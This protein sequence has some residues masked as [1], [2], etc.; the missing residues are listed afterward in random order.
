MK[1][2]IAGAGEV[3]SHLAKMLSNEN[4]DIILI[5]TNEEHLKAVGANLDVLTYVGSATSISILK[6]AAIKNAGLFIAATESEE[7]NITAAILGKKL[8]ALKS[9]ARIDNPEFLYPGNRE[10]FTSFG[11]DY[12]I[13]PEKIAAKEIV[14]LL[15]KTGTTEVVDFDGGKLSLFVIKLE[16]NAPVLDKTM[17]EAS[18]GEAEMEFR[19]VAITRDNETLIPRGEDKFEANDLIYVI[20]NQYGIERLMEYSGKEQYDIR[21]IMILGGSRVGKMTAKDLGSHHNVKLIEIDRRKSYQ[22]SN[23]LDN[24]LV[25]NGD[26]RNIDLLME[27]GLDKM[28]AFIAVTGNSE[29]NMLSCLLARRMGVKKTIAEIENID[30]IRLAENMGIDTII[31]KKFITASRIFRF[32]MSEEVNS[33][34]CLTGTDAEVMEFIAKPDS[35]VVQGKIKDIDF[36]KDSIIG[37][38]IRGK[39]SF[40]A[41]GETRIKPFDKVVV[42]ALPT[43]IGKVGKYFN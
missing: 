42:F 12:M 38:V 35:K 37:G 24:T 36:P 10:I 39:S 5:D 28:D 8:G 19:A 41:K 2:V 30:Y 27:E 23:Y 40:I 6:D 16:E 33:I 25:I 15:H 9:I 14:G 20:T 26:G 17:I 29:T 22:L 4:H 3:G 34:K 43:A 7:I 1:I 32:T 21:N 31:N 18:D 13:Y 11:I